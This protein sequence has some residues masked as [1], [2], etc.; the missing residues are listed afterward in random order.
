M[1]RLSVLLAV[2]GLLPAQTIVL[3]HANLIDGVSAAM[4]GGADL[5]GHLDALAVIA[6]WGALGAYLAVRGFSW[7][8]SR[9]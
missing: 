1:L 7:E 5:G 3:Q 2:A 8:Q 6:L 4:V 9:S